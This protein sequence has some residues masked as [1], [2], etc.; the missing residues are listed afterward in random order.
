MAENGHDAR[1]KEC[2]AAV[3]EVNQFCGSCGAKMVLDNDGADHW[4]VRLLDSEGVIESSAAVMPGTQVIGGD[5]RA[6][7]TIDEDRCVSPRHAFIRLL[8]AEVSLEDSG[9]RNGV[10]RP[11][12]EP[13]AAGHNDL[14]RAGGQLFRLQLIE[15][16]GPEP[17]IPLPH[18][19]FGP[20]R[21]AWGRLLRYN[22]H[23]YVS[24]SRLL[25]ADNF[26]VGRQEGDWTLRRARTMSSR[27][28]AIQRDDD[29]AITIHDQNSRNGSYVEVSGAVSIS[30]GDQFLI[31]DRLI[32]FDAMTL[33]DFH[34]AIR[35]G[36][37][38][39][40]Q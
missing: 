21:P 17:V 7:I 33:K 19:L 13:V 20:A 38:L 30:S 36:D 16:L 12:R 14:I 18:P 10:F 25:D 9:S 29:G 37:S 8:D 28:F 35:A 4:L 26:E 40:I 27:H 34:L 22:R 5:E 32:Q 6:D 23:G 3:P 31:G 39:E 24:E 2:G 1:C 15:R 11:V